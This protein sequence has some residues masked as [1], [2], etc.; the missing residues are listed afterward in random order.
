MNIEDSNNDTSRTLDW[1]RYIEDYDLEMRHLHTWP[2]EK[3]LLQ[4]HQF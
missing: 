4:H 1:V 3:P 2:P